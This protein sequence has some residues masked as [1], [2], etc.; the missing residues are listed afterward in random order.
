MKSLSL[1][2]SLLLFALVTDVA[3]A[4]KPA[5]QIAFEDAAVVASGLTPGKPVVWFGVEHRRRTARPASSSAMPR[6]RAPNDLPQK[7][8]GYY[9]EYVH[10]AKRVSHAGMQRVVTGQGGEIYYTPDHCYTFFRVR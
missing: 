2:L 8:P 9:H 5:P 1:P 7:P 4:Q 3:F 10:P 6:R